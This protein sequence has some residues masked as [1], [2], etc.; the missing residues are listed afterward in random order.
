ME[1]DYEQLCRRYYDGSMSKEDW[2]DWYDER[3]RVVLEH[4]RAK[5]DFYRRHLDGIDVSTVSSAEL[6]GLPFTTKADLRREMHA[7]LCGDVADAAIYYETTGTTGAPTPC[8]RG[9]KDIAWSNTHVEQSWRHLFGT[10]FGDRMPVVGLMG[11][12]ELYAF[13]DTFGEVTQ[14][15]GACHTK[16]WPESSRVGFAKAL[17]L[18]KQLRVEV[19]VCA[20]T[21]CLTLAKAARYHGYDLAS[22]FD[23][24]LFLVLG[25]ICTDEFAANVRSLWGAD[26]LPGL[27]GSQ[28][29]L[30]IATG[31]ANNRLHLSQP[32][33]VAEVIDP[34]SDV[35]LGR[36]GVG[37]LCL[38]ML[39]DG[40]KPLIRYRTGDLVELGGACCGCGQPGT[41]VRVIG[42]VDDRV[43]IGAGRYQPADI[44]SAILSGVRGCLGYQVVIDSDER[45]TVRMELLPGHSGREDIVRAETIARLNA[46]FGVDAD[47]L[48]TAELDPV[49]NTGAFVSWKAARILDNRGDEGADVRIAR[50]VAHRYSYTS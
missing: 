19:V 20:P 2:S 6:A 36:E 48:V 11:P 25:E 46:R 15:M 23:V 44:E 50:E 13:G 5:S 22:D 21:L 39:I 49:T 35:T 3:L 43:A 8:P 18:L 24:K 38:T 42:R 14:R 31:C 47:V 30:A 10:Y 12:S 29:A 17:R 16:I 4:V 40:S 37:E 32:N 34:D 9:A 26:V 28:E 45:L 33:Y 7:V 1:S 41:V 27:Y